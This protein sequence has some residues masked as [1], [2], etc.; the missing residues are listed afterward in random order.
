MPMPEW[1]TSIARDHPCWDGYRPLLDALPAGGF[2]AP[3]QLNRVLPPEARTRAEHAVR[4]VPAEHLPGVDYERHIYET[5][6]IATRGN[7]HDLCNALVWCRLPRFKAAMNALHYDH[8]RDEA[9]GRR[10]P[11]RDALTLLDESGVI[12]TGDAPTLFAALAAR[13]WPRA[14][15]SLRDEWRSVRVVVCGHAILEKF[16][17]PYKALTAHAL[18]L[19]GPLSTADA[20]LDQRLEAALLREGRLGAPAD[21]DP[22]P[23]MGIPGWWTGGAQDAAFYADRT[24]FRPPRG[25]KSDAGGAQ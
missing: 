5:G 10:G 13:D 7:W 23:L 22:L 3:A 20:A 15:V 8:L 24:V 4:F 11:L 21:L 18:Y 2:P 14:F 17:Q 1:K 19:S 25:L 16:L 6:E 9:G 12:V